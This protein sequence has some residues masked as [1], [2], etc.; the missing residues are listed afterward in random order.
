LPQPSASFGDEINLV[1]CHSYI[2]G[3]AATPTGRWCDGNSKR[4]RPDHGSRGARVAAIAIGI[5]WLRFWRS[6][7]P[8]TTAKAGYTAIQP[9]SLWIA[10]L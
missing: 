6:I 8:K 4:R 1:L 7:A 10:A 2:L 5:S 3:L 9:C